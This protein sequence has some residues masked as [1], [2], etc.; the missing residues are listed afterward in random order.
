ML[1]NTTGFRNIYIAAGYTDLRRGI[2]GLASIVKFNFQ[3]DPYEKGILF[4]FCGRRSDRIKG[5]VWEGDGFLL[6]YKRL[7]LGGFSWPRTK[8]EA[9]EIILQRLSKASMEN[10]R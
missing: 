6:L 3:L 8:E 10:S 1:N 7:E 4:L 5:L 9:L 2:D